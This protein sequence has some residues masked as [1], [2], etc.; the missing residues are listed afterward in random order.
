LLCRG[1]FCF[2]R[3]HGANL[4]GTANLTRGPAA[5]LHLRYDS[6]STRRALSEAAKGRCGALSRSRHGRARGRRV[7]TPRSQIPPF[8]GDGRGP[9]SSLSCSL[10]LLAG[11]T[12]SAIPSVKRFKI[13]TPRLWIGLHRPTCTICSREFVPSQT[14]TEGTCYDSTLPARQEHGNHSRASLADCAS[15]HPKSSAS[16]LG[17]ARK[18]RIAECVVREPEHVALAQPSD[19]DVRTTGFGDQLQA[20][21]T[22]GPAQTPHHL[23]QPD[24]DCPCH[25]PG[26]LVWRR[27]CAIRPSMREPKHLMLA[28]P[29]DRRVEQASD[30]VP[31]RQ[32]TLD[33][34]CDEAR[35][36]E[37]ERDRHVD[38]ALAAGLP[39]RDAVD[40][41]GAGLDLG[42]PLP[43]TRDCGDEFSPGYRSG[44]A[45][46][47]CATGLWEQ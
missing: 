37:G 12:I 44:S 22:A 32:P 30:S 21:E 17:K 11:M 43:S 23:T 19:R 41:Y 6:A 7:L 31:V 13:T 39:C 38:V 8:E 34:G 36:E 16:I 10:F 20:A 46:P 47:L 3:S 24:Q 42:Q 9:I 14:G 2:A 1:R 28:R 26:R 25:G 29:R 33:G 45:W 27:T 5:S 40:C 15:S 35:C 4:T 18:Y